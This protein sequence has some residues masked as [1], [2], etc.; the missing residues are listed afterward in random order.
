MISSR[1]ILHSNIHS[2]EGH[3]PV[4][5]SY[6]AQSIEEHTDPAVL[7]LCELWQ[8]HL[9][10]SSRFSND[11][12]SKYAVPG[13]TLVLA[14]APKANAIAASGVEGNGGLGFYVREGVPHEL[15]TDPTLAPPCI[16]TV[17][18]IAWLM[19]RLP[20][21]YII[22][23][24]YLHASASIAD[25]NSIRTACAN[26]EARY[27]DVPIVL[28]GDMNAQDEHWGSSSRE[29]HGKFVCDRLIDSLH[30]PCLNATMA[31]GVPT[32]RPDPFHQS[33]ILDLVLVNDPS[34]VVN[35]HVADDLDFG[36]DHLPTSVTLLSSCDSI[37][38]SGDPLKRRRWRFPKLKNN[39]KA[40]RARVALICTRYREALDMMVTAQVNPLLPLDSAAAIDSLL[41]RLCECM[42][43]AA[44]SVF[45]ESAAQP[46]PN[47]WMHDPRVRTAVSEFRSA[48]S[49]CH[50]DG[51]D[52]AKQLRRIKQRDMR[53]IVREVKNERWYDFSSKLQD[54]KNRIVWSVWH[55]S[56]GTNQKGSLSN[57]KDAAGVLPPTVVHALTNLARHYQ[58][59]CDVSDVVGVIAI[60]A[61]VSAL[62]SPT[63][64]LHPSTIADPIGDKE[65]TVEE[66][67]TACK[68]IS[69]T[70]APGP[71][72]LH[73]M[74]VK[75]TGLVWHQQF[76]RL[77]NTMH[78]TGHVPQAWR[79]ADIVSLFKKGSRTDP[80]NY[81]PIS[82]T[83]V[84]ARLY[85]RIILR[86]L[87]LLIDP[88]LN[89]FQF[90]F[91]RK[92]STV[93]SIALLL[94]RI[95][96]ALKCKRINKQLAVA[97]LDLV[98][99]FDKV[100]HPSLLYK[101]SNHFG[102]NGRLW[103]F[104]SAFLQ[105]RRART[106]EGEHCSEW[107]PMN[108]GVPQGSVTG[109]I[110]F[111]VYINDL[112][113]QIRLETGCDPFAFADDLAIAPR[114]SQFYSPDEELRDAL[115]IA[116]LWS[117]RWRM[118]FAAGVE[119]SAV[120]V[121]RSRAKSIDPSLRNYQLDLGV[122]RLPRFVPLPSAE[123]YK[124]LG[125][126][127]DARGSWTPHWKHILGKIRRSSFYV[128]RLLRGLHPD[129]GIHMVN[130]VIR[131]AFSYAMAFWNPSNPQLYRMNSSMAIPLKRVFG[132][133]V[134]THTTGVLVACGIP[135]AKAI[136]EHLMM[137]TAAHLCHHLLDD[138]PAKEMFSHAMSLQL[139]ARI[140]LRAPL[141]Q[142][143]QSLMNS[144]YWV[145]D[146][147]ELSDPKEERALL[148][149]LCLRRGFD[150]WK[151]GADVWSDKYHASTAPIKQSYTGNVMHQIVREPSITVQTASTAR[152]CARLRHGR[153]AYH[154]RCH[155]YAVTSKHYVPSPDC[156][157]CGVGVRETAEH[158]LLH[159]PS[160]LVSRFKLEC[161]LE[162]CS[163]LN[164]PVPPLSFSLLTGA[165]PSAWKHSVKL[166]C[167]W[168]TL[169]GAFVSR[170]H[171][172]RP[173]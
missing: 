11:P 76:A 31:F 49:A 63:N 146:L 19:V 138:N 6:L 131:P 124:Y 65:W 139:P 68:R 5:Q 87:W 40:E 117:T 133:P 56:N 67:T 151:G 143:V 148:R 7:A 59:V 84:L 150:F 12:Y 165:V 78:H 80:N 121:F 41:Q 137:R 79:D 73:P 36:S 83:S 57:V 125:L 123:S 85:E 147:D 144:G 90:G 101:L 18:Q 126:W 153:A 42:D 134:S 128:T 44:L 43:E 127:L 140:K 167:A 88:H 26:V 156:E 159:C 164:P 22:G 27:P 64:P 155:T 33:S 45:G 13:Y 66:I 169:T 39:T 106:I 61:K 104:V 136:H 62:L 60:D 55:R 10:L 172:L 149:T 170:V 81:R 173:F 58:R 3:A 102:V 54:E 30:W 24:C 48:S 162:S 171:Q 163:R 53:C 94:Q 112:L 111:L 118:S 119:K 154:A 47:W 82:L 158:V 28:G 91:R 99:A 120:T 14:A 70:S 142:H 4:I 46:P 29:G 166:C 145:D 97:F 2:L 98:K 160:L 152:L 129:I 122:G 38:P 20:R 75:H 17:T 157:Q 25:L 89:R 161:D 100:H 130:A 168:W 86:R 52:A 16:N 96:A 95:S 21:A 110:L 34:I 23:V 32:R 132:L 105:G 141:S 72:G 135:P 51:S 1:R 107:V 50:S 77:V 15:L 92:R 74:L 103:C 9:H 113:D 69:T 115:R 116:G 71:D 108:A 109:P 93:D 8:S 35:M 37:L 114:L